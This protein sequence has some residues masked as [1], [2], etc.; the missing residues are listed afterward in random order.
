MG[1]DKNNKKKTKKIK[2]RKEPCLVCG[3]ITVR[4]VCGEHCLKKF[5]RSFLT[6]KIRNYTSLEKLSEFLGLSK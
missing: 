5:L 2:L 1:K 3:K 4:G 6:K